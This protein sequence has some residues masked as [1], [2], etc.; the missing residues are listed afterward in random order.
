MKLVKSLLLGSA[1]GLAAVA[2]A[3][4]ADLPM[5]KAAPVEYVRVCS[6]HGVGFFYIPGTET[7]LRVSGFARF[8]YNVASTR[9]WAQDNTGFRSIGRLNLDARTQT[10]YGTL[11]SFVRFDMARR[12]GHF[13]SG[14]AQ[15]RGEAEI[16]TG[17]DFAG[18]AQTQI[19]LDKAFIQF[20]GITAGRATSFY[21]FYSNDLNFFGITGSDRGATNLLAYTATF[22]GGWS[23]TLSMEDPQER[24]YPIIG[25]DAAG[26]PTLATVIAGAGAVGGSVILPGPLGGPFNVGL[27]QKN[28][29]PDIVAN[30]RVDQTWGSFQLSG[31]IHQISVVGTTNTQVG[32]PTIIPGVV[33]P[34]TGIAGPATVIP[35]NVTVGTQGF[36]PDTEYGYAI[37]AGL[38]VNLP[39]IAPGDL[40]YLQAA[41][42]RGALDYTISGQWVFGGATGAQGGFGGTL[43]RFAVNTVD[44]IVDQFGETRLSRSWSAVAAFLH[45]WTPQLRSGFSVGYSNI[46]YPGANTLFV[47][48][49]IPGTVFNPAPGAPAF[50][51]GSAAQTF[52]TTGTLRDFRVLNLAANL[53]W[54]PVRDLDIGVEVA[55]DRINV[56]GRVVDLNKCGNVT[57]FPAGFFGAGTPAQVCGHTTN[58]EDEWRGRLRIHRNF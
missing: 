16:P 10:A 57:V 26:I 56:S 36:R 17:V 53:I 41:Y 19:T 9:G 6:A 35:N 48:G 40:L 44:G 7:C 29:M 58:H 38:K 51:F 27:Q 21:D 8:E 14:T 34:I 52:A 3:Q 2:G 49:V 55:Y 1:A 12:T 13:F 43:G 32:V 24:R 45:Y 30:V 39:W 31:A 11:R 42:A 18:K 33:N 54:S 50:T 47:G 25:L 37:Q 15:R 22:G 20:A 23:A 46:E 4:A 28:S 5:R